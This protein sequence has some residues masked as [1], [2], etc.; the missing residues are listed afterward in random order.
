MPVWKDC[1]PS[2]RST[3]MWCSER[4]SGPVT[5]WSN[6]SRLAMKRTSRLAGWVANPPKMKSR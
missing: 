6:S 5:L 4:I 3:S 2:A 1:I